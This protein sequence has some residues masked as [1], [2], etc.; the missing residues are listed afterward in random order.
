MKRLFFLIGFLLLSTTTFA[1]TSQP[2]TSQTTLIF[3][4]H[5]EKMDDGT[6]DPSLNDA[7]KARA[8]KLAEIMLTDYEVSAI[9]STPYK[10]T[11][12]TAAPLADSLGMKIQDYGLSDPR[13]LVE[14][15]KETNKGKTALIVGHSNTTPL[16]VNITLGEEQFKQL[17]E[18]EYD[19]LFIVSIDEAGKASAEKITY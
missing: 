19:Q 17:D 14:M 13:G 11:Q 4:R 1:Q 8:Q 5:A 2:P 9:Y 16:L 6:K 12:E 15:L 7:G 10:R 18:N 3:V